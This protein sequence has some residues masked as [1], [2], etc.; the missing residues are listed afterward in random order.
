MR[1]ELIIKQWFIVQRA[2]YRI[3]IEHHNSDASVSRTRFNIQNRA[4]SL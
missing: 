4:K 3:D 1:N 2:Y